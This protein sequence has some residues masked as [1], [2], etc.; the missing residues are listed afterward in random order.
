MFGSSCLI[1]S[2]LWASQGGRFN[3]AFLALSLLGKPSFEGAYLLKNR[4]ICADSR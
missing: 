3:Q 1:V 2:K 4:V